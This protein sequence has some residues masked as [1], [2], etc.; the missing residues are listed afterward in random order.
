MVTDTFLLPDGFLSGYEC[1]SIDVPV[2]NSATMTGGVTSD[3]HE[4]CAKSHRAIHGQDQ[5]MRR[6]FS[7]NG[8]VRRP[9]V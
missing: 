6:A 1:G 3:N 4:L 5:D 8:Q 2:H 9:L 7:E